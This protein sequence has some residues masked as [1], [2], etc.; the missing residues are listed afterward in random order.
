MSP[1]IV[2]NL[3]PEWKKQDEVEEKG[4]T[5]LDLTGNP[6]ECNASIC[7][8]L[9]PQADIGIIMMA[10]PCTTIPEMRIIH[11][12]NL[13]SILDCGRSVYKWYKYV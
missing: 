4:D 10:Y 5:T 11:L 8:L 9:N 6:L 12:E 13:S 1:T 3:F 7:W 2:S